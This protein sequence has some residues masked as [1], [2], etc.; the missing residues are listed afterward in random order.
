MNLFLVT[1]LRKVSSSYEEEDAL[2]P[3]LYIQQSVDA[4]CDP[5]SYALCLKL[6]ALQQNKTC[7]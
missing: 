5:K 4:L 2:R 6:L 7:V 3:R 1:I